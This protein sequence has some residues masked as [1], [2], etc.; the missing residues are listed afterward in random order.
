M[1]YFPIFVDLQDKPCLVVGGGRVSLRKATTLLQYGANVTVV[2]PRI[3]PQFRELNVRVHLREFET[4]DL[5]GVFL[6]VTATDNHSLNSNILETCKAM[7][8]L[9]NSA[10]NT[11]D[12]GYTFPATA[13]LEDISIGVSTS[14]KSPYVSS[15]IKSEIEREVLPKYAKAVEV[16]SRWKPYVLD[17]IPDSTAR[18]DTI[19][20][21]VDYTIAK[22]EPTKEEIADMINH[23]KD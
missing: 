23:C 6:V 9:C 3:V 12:N 18:R 4:K 17:T 7:N 15:L 20:H 13:Q 2:S 14:G 11:T 8:I 16:S 21:L 22:G 19:K 5:Q 10:T 1:A